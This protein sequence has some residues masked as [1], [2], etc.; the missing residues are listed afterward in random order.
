MNLMKYRKLFI[1]IFII[2][3]AAAAAAWA[4]F[5]LNLGIDFTGGTV[6]RYPLTAEQYERA[7]SGEIRNLLVSG[8]LAQLDLKP[9]PPQPY[10]H[11]DL[12]TGLDVYGVIVKTRALKG[13]T[14]QGMILNALN[15]YF[16]S[17]VARDRL[18]I[19]MVDPAIGRETVLNSFY[20]VLIACLLILVYIAI[21]FE[22]K[23]GVAGVLALIH[24][25]LV[26]IGL[27]ALLRKEI[28][29]TII[30]AL[31]TIIGYSINDTI[32]VFDRVRENMRSRRKGQGFDE[33]VNES[34]L[35]TMRR[36][37]NTAATTVLA[38]LVL[39]LVGSESIKDFCLA[40]IVGITA[41]TYSSIFVAGALWAAWKNWEERRQVAG[42]PMP[43]A[44]K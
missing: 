35:Q 16:G 19:S 39:Y 15:G 22:F 10:T 34:V 2:T 23:S 1:L 3:I 44:R 37:L 26:V 8:E 33:L 27:F 12:S 41:G 17:E 30:A 5:G 31:L 13:W 14:E 11:K 21:R 20:A 29:A 18:Q 6:I 36:S 40:L 32:V 4:G 42:K 28:D 38:V 25:T 9:G 7:N 24:D 43:A